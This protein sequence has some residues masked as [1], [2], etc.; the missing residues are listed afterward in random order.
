M[1]VASKVRSLLLNNTQKRVEADA[2]ICCVESMSF[3]QHWLDTGCSE[4]PLVHEGGVF[5]DRVNRI[6]ALDVYTVNMFLQWQSQLRT[7]AIT[8]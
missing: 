1:S 2:S 8:S 3:D 4:A 6:H 7:S 5:P